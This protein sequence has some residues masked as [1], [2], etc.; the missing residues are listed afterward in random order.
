MNCCHCGG[1]LSSILERTRGVCSSCHL[2]PR[3]AGEDQVTAQPEASSASRSSSDD[4]I[5]VEAISGESPFSGEPLPL[6]A[7]VSDL[8]SGDRTVSGSTGAD[9]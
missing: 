1:I 2:L 5:V 6:P 3:S 7:T 9:A 8:Q 4:D